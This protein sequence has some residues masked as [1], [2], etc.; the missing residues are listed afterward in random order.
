MILKRLVFYYF[1]EHYDSQYYIHLLPTYFFKQH[2]YSCSDICR[3]KHILIY[4]DK[5][6]YFYQYH[7]WHENNYFHYYTESKQLYEHSIDTK[8]EI[9]HSCWY[10]DKLIYRFEVYRYSHESEISFYE[11]DFLT[12]HFKLIKNI[13]INI[14]IQNRIEAY[15]LINKIAN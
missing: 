6:E 8:S 3:Q 14:D 5:Y 11:Y 13:N 2:S 4:P 1:N 9:I 15:K 10:N 12:Q 7:Y